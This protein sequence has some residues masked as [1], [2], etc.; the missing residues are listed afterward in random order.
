MAISTS[1]SAQN[2]SSASEQASI[3]DE[4][5]TTSAQLKEAYGI[6]SQDIAHL[7]REIGPDATK[8]TPEQD[9][10]RA[11]MQKSLTQLEGMLTTVN[12]A[13]EE[14]WV[15]IKAKAEAVRT[16]ALSLVKERTG[17]K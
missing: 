14:Q 9:A 7:N 6:L 3:Q 11:R 1:V 4:I 13:N 17:G 15:E 12:T 5:R 8:A 16:G 10:M 2:A